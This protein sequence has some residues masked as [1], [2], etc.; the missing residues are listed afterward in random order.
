GQQSAGGAAGTPVDR[1]AA[2][3]RG[4]GGAAVRAPRAAARPSPGRAARRRWQCEHPPGEGG[5]L[6]PY[7]AD[8]H[9]PAFYAPPRPPRH[10][11]ALPGLVSGPA[12][13]FALGAHA[14]QP[15]FE[16]G[17]IRNRVRLAEAQQE[18]AALTYQKA[19]QQAFREV[20]DA[21]IAYQKSQEFRLQQEQ[22]TR[23]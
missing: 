11:A 7:F 21:L 2:R 13:L 15:I 16:G 23:S 5:L 14:A 8:P 18:E 12:G 9:R 6:P 17:R 3:A 22:L 20:A 4:P 10:R 19:V 1:T